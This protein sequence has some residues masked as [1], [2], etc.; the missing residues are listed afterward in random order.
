MRNQKKVNGST[1]PW[2]QD[3]QA[4]DLAALPL[5]NDESDNII[6]AEILLLNV[7]QIKHTAEGA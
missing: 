3:T 7:W 5:Q 1:G 6:P 4:L 2:T